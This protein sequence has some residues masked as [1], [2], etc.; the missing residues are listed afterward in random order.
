M[1]KFLKTLSI[2]LVGFTLLATPFKAYG[3]ENK[4]PTDISSNFKNATKKALERSCIYGLE[5]LL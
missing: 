3:A 4:K 1:K 2:S 5:V